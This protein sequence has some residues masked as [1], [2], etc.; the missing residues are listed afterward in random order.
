MS[1]HRHATATEGSTPVSGAMAEAM[2]ATGLEPG[3]SPSP[4]RLP[5]AGKLFQHR[6]K[7]LRSLASGHRLSSWLAFMA[8]LSDVQHALA[9]VPAAAAPETGWLS[10]LEQLRSQLR[11]MLPAAAETALEDLPWGD[12]EALN[13]LAARLLTGAANRE[14][15]GGAPFIVAALQVAWTRHA[16]GL[17]A[18]AVSASA[19][20]GH[21]PVC[22]SAPVAGVIH[23]GSEIGG[24]RYL[25][26]GLC[27]TA[28]H[29]VRSAC[30]A[31]GEGNRIELRLIEAGEDSSNGSNDPARAE[32]CESCNGYLKLFLM[33]KAPGLDP[34]ADD[35]A[36]FALDI[37]VGD[38]GFQRIG[39]NP[40]LAQAG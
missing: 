29:H 14:D 35:L 25:H 10:D 33:E 40:F 34:V 15:I 20:A 38:E 26:C 16:G 17:E 19:V 24:L 9:T 18:G 3:R 11:G 27:H 39:G 23:T 4:V 37:L 32:T 8:Q 28:W 31:C 2:A 21:C 7:R 13:A 30:V 12:R 5:D 22:G 1:Q 6:A 36:S